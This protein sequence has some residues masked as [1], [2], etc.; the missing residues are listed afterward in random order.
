MSLLV[1]ARKPAVTVPHDAVVLDVVRTMERERIGAV[2]V[3]R[4]DRLLGVFTERDVMIRVV[5]AGGD[6][7]SIPVG[8]VMTTQVAT[9]DDAMPYGDALRM[10]LDRHFRHLPIVDR[11]RRVL[12]ML[13]LRHLLR[14]RIDEL[15][16]QLDSV[17]G[18]LGADGI[19]G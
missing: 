5:L 15:A 1:I 14:H 12:G 7:R 19:G 18:Y 2:A 13:S 8:E 17:V 9:A 11:D 6:A 3:V 4:D 16:Q 10:M